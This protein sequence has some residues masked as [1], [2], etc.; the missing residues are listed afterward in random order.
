M[1]IAVFSGQ[2]ST[3]NQPG[4]VG[5]TSTPF[6]PIIRVPLSFC[7]MHKL[8]DNLSTFTCLLKH[9][10]SRQ[11]YS[12]SRICTAVHISSLWTRHH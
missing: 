12:K 5:V 4:L 2:P 3:S 7:V 9:A 8:F 6:S 1:V 10:V 11:T